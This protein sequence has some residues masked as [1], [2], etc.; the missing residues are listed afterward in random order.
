MYRYTLRRAVTSV[1]VLF[2]VSVVTYLMMYLTPGDPAE[3][4]LR[5]QTVHDQ[6]AVER[7]RE[8]YR[9][10]EPVWIQYGHWLWDVLHGDF[11]RSYVTNRPV[12]AMV[13][14]NA[15]STA[16]LAVAA[17]AIALAIAVPAG[18]VSAVHQGEVSDSVSQFGSLLG[19]SMPNFWLGYVLILV[20]SIGVPVRS[21]GVFPV[22]GAGSLDRLVLP[23]LTLGSGVAAIMTR[24]LRS[25][26]LE[27][28]EEDY[29]R[30]AR[31]KG[32]AERVVVYKHAFRNALVPVVTVAGIQ[33][34]YLLNG[35]VVVEIVFA[36]PGLGTLVIDA[37]FDRDYPVIQATTLVIAAL[38]VGINF[39]VD[40]TYRY[41]DP[42]IDLRRGRR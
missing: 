37:L 7:F 11:G 20:F 9:L 12:S 21:L 33:F 16:I 26:M 36:R 27:V 35:A 41:I 3:L 19:V 5:A 13:V 2:G 6:A 10:D 25:A 29:V 38:F 4:V 15:P 40:V 32:L 28:L 1:F 17:M 42:R 31:S 18:V 14:D 22:S 8:Q 34:G 30:T 24:L 39:L 23:A